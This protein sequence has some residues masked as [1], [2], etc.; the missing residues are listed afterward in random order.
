MP[1]SEMRPWLPRHC[2]WYA[3]TPQNQPQGCSRRAERLTY[4]LV[5]LLRL[6]NVMRVASQSLSVFTAA[7]ARAGR[8]SPQRVV[9]LARAGPA[10][11]AERSRARASRVP[12]LRRSRAPLLVQ[13]SS[14][15][16]EEA[17]YVDL[18][19]G[20]AFFKVRPGGWVRVPRH[21][22]RTVTQRA[23]GRP[24][25]EAVI[26]PWRLQHVVKALSDGGIRGVTTYDV[27]GLGAQGGAR[28]RY[29]GH[30][31]DESSLVDKC[32]VEIVVTASQVN[33]VVSMII[34]AAQTG[35]IGDGA[36]RAP[37][38]GHTRRRHLVPWAWVCHKPSNAA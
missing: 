17:L 6:C 27:R 25:V 1:T 11:G 20:F 15:S 26:R 34:G 30:E 29:A 4:C 12:A 24:Q 7:P 31:F 32:K 33:D 14:G 5:R 13:A 16:E 3:D 36:H 18:S 10:A 37:D 9:V 23:W 38:C 28:E 19:P 35:E 8:P 22:T 21:S 2:S